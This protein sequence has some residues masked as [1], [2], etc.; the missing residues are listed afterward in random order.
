[1]L[2]EVEHIYTYDKKGN[3]DIT[4][5]PLSFDPKTF[6]QTTAEMKRR[7]LV[8][9]GLHIGE[10]AVFATLIDEVGVTSNEGF[11]ITDRC[12]KEDALLTAYS[13][14]QQF[15]SEYVTQYLANTIR[16]IK[17]SEFAQFKIPELVERIDHYYPLR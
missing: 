15:P 17:P 4:Y 6:P 1:M 8:T 3:V 16:S 14:I 5:H 13:A 11:L 2:F 7:S 9:S 12:N 10:F